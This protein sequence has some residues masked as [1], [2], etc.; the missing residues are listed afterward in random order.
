MFTNGKTPDILCWHQI[1]TVLEIIMVTRND[2]A[3]RKR[4]IVCPQVVHDYNYYKGGVDHVNQLRITNSA[5][6]ENQK[7]SSTKFSGICYILCLILHYI[8]ANTWK[9]FITGFLSFNCTRIHNF[10]RPIYIK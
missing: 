1:T 5:L 6:I 10:M 7:S 4:D 8:Q 2:K 3:R 9:H